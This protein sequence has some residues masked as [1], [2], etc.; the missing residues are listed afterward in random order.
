M[1][2]N[3]ILLIS[4]E[5]LKLY[6]PIGRNI[7]QDKVFPFVL[8][9]QQLS[10]QPI[11]GQALYEELQEQVA[12]EDITPSNKALLLKIAPYLALQSTFL[13][14]RSLSYTLT[15]KGATKE[16][17][18]NSE[19][20]NEKEIGQWKLD[21]MGL[22]DDAKRLLIDFLCMC[23]ENY[24]LWAPSTEIE[25]L[26]KKRNVEHGTDGLIYFPKKKKTDGCGCGCN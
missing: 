13:A 7:S 17:S 21:V 19:A 14:L 4:E 9:A 10:L 15:E 22:V 16:K 24:P 6:S 8:L 25:C 3:E 20:L 5:A 1:A 18:E 23:R 2:N 11:L 26:C 12:S